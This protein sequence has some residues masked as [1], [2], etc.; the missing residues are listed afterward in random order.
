MSGVW[1]GSVAYRLERGDGGREDAI[2][3][4]E[5]DGLLGRELDPLR[6]RVRGAVVSTMSRSGRSPPGR[7]SLHG[8]RSTDRRGWAA[9]VRWH[10]C[11]AHLPDHVDELADRQVGG[12][13]EL[14]LRGRTEHRRARAHT[15]NIVGLE[16]GRWH[17][18]GWA[19][20]E[21]G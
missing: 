9:G 15:R 18:G 13:K 1:G 7:G 8:H 4:E 5:E 21:L 20:L 12:H 17:E 19:G 10:G 11:A 14:F 16:A 6:E 3:N 2:C